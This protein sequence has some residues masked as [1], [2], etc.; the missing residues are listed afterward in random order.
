MG[1]GSDIIDLVKKQ[2]KGKTIFLD[3]EAIY[4]GCTNRAERIKRMRFYEKNGFRAV[5]SIHK[6]REENFQ[7]MVFGEE[8]SEHQIEEFWDEFGHLWDEP[9]VAK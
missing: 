3:C 4:P 8:I 1:L 7:T 2:A 5:G 9:D 6:W